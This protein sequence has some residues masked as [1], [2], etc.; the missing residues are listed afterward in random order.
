[1]RAE[2]VVGERIRAYREAAGMTQE[3]LGRVVGA[4]LGREW[5]RQAVSAAEKGSR[6]FT[7]SELVAIAYAL[8]INIAMLFVPSMG[9]PE[10]TLPGAALREA[11]LMSTV[12]AVPGAEEDSGRVLGALSQASDHTVAATEASLAAANALAELGP[13]VRDLIARADSA[14]AGRKDA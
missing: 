2:Q 5:P 13:L 1:V 6:G 4:L 3:D 14:P 11:D 7:A 10:I 9:D 12:L 8:R